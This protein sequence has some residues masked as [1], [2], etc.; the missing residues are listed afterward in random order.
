MLPTEIRANSPTHKK[1]WGT[2]ALKQAIVLAMVMLILNDMLG[3]AIKYYCANSSLIYLSYIPILF[4]GIV[5]IGYFMIYGITM[6]IHKRMGFFLL[7]F[8]FSAIYA[9][10]T[11]RTPEAVGFGLYIWLPFFLGMLVTTFGLQVH[12][13]KNVALWWAIATI[14]VIINS[15]YQFP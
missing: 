12:F 15:F 1:S 7:L 9:I 6:H 14:G 10:G 2:Y 8:L 3:G 5:V 4:A 13:Q 11:G